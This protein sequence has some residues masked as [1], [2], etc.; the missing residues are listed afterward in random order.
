VRA[1]LGGEAR[2][3]GH[4]DLAL[5]VLRDA[6]A[7]AD[8]IGEPRD[9]VLARLRLA[10]VHQWREEWALSDSL[11]AGCLAAAESLDARDRSFVAQHAGKNHFDQGRW[12]EAE[13]LFERALTL[14]G[15][16]G[17]AALVESSRVA[18]EAARGR[19]AAVTS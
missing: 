12:A 6:V 10:H 1:R 5:D 4:L 18:L 9:R 2:A 16:L 19:L 3:A 11:F 13:A 14:R 8:R 7:L 17:D 15:E